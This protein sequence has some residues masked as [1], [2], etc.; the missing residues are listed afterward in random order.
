LR[1][2][3]ATAGGR[4]SLLPIDEQRDFARVYIEL[5]RADRRQLD[6][7]GQAWGRL[8]A[9]EGVAHPTAETLA[10]AREALGQARHNSFQIR[11]TIGQATLYASRIGIKGDYQLAVT[12]RGVVQSVCVPIET[13]REKAAAIT[14]HPAGI[15]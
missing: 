1:W 2:E 3:A 12:N 13:P 15:P 14:Q 10:R 5:V 11:S 6:E 7:E 8:A 9:L 4:T